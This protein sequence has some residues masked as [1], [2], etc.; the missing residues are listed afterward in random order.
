M[1]I[2]QD[3]IMQIL[4]NHREELVAHMVEETKTEISHKINWALASEIDKIV[5]EFITVEIGPEIKAQLTESKPTV[6][7]AVAQMAEEF[8]TDLAKAL[9]DQARENLKTSYKRSA[10]LKSLVE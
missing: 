9:L 3:E 2:T 8:S 6:L 5:R 10:I 4:E 1:P 7:K